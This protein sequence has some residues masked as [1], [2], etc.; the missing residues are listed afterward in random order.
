MIYK[1]NLNNLNL[2]S[3][4]G[5]MRNF[6]AAA[7][8]QITLKTAIKLNSTCSKTNKN[9]KII[10][11]QSRQLLYKTHNGS[12]NEQG[13]NFTS[14]CKHLYKNTKGLSINHINTV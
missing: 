1:N 2:H 13:S 4:H 11:K 7:E 5:W 10:N 8:E 6:T 12:P 14:Q 3:S 9:Y